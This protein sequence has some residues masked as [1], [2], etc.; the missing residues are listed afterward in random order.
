MR[1]V[2]ATAGN[3]VGAGDA[4]AAFILVQRRLEQRRRVPHCD[5][6]RAR[7]PEICCVRRA[8]RIVCAELKR[9][10]C[11]ACVAEFVFVHRA[12]GFEQH[13]AGPHGDCSCVRLFAIAP[14]QD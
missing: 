14:A 9:Q 11:C 13:I 4:D 12:A 8:E 1:S 2:V 3:Q 6:I 7:T 5:R 10:E